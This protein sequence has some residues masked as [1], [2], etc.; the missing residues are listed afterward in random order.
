[1]TAPESLTTQFE[2]LHAERVRTLDPKKLAKNVATRAALVA[3]FDPAKIAKVGE[4]LEPLDL[5]QSDG[6]S[7]SLDALVADGPALLIFF[8]SAGCPACNLALPYYD[9]QVRPGL[10]KRGIKL[11]AISPHLPERGLGEIKIR[12]GLGFTL[13]CDR[14][15]R[16][17]RRIGITYAK[18]EIPKGD[19]VPG[20][21]G[22]F[23]GTGTAELPQPS[24]ILI[25]RDRT[26]RFVEV[27]PDWLVRTEAPAIFSA[28]DQFQA[29]AAA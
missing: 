20:W 17:G 4:I 25:D 19:L 22:E 21:T 7:I 14:N 29:E 6:R 5:T 26:I 18:N 8:R 9:R 23:T 1:M 13:V 12:H 2:K 27:S 28:V 11:V 15:N 10:E 3:A 24:V 16:L